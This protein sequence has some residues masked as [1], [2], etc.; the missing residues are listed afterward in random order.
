MPRFHSLILTLAG[1]DLNE[2]HGQSC[3]LH[4]AA[5][6]GHVDILR[7]LLDSG[8]EAVDD[9][10]GRSALHCA[11]ALGRLEAVQFLASHNDGKTF[12][13]ATLSGGS[14]ILHRAAAAVRRL[15]CIARI[16]K[17]LTRTQGKHHVVAW[18]LKQGLLPEAS[19]DNG[20]TA[21]HLALL[22]GWPRTIHVLLTSMPDPAA[23]L[24]QRTSEGASAFLLAV[25]MGYVPLAQWVRS[26]GADINATNARGEGAV[27]IVR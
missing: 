6:R 18:A 2:R 10:Q 11:A 4:M 20:F 8:A 15:A 7:F 17:G 16:G 19:T 13:I 3:P 24:A 26:T 25:A 22:R 9:G 21:L 23:Q 5:Q 14:S 12:P 27:L 1:S